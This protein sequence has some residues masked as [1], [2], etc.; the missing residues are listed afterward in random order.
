MRGLWLAAALGAAV[1]GVGGEARAFCV[2]RGCSESRQDCEYDARGCLLSGPVLHWASSCVSFGVQKDGSPRRGIS[3]DT[4]HAAIV[5]GFSQWMNARCG[6]GR[7]PSIRLSDS[8][9]IECRTPEYNED[10]P[11]ANVLMF[12]DDDWPYDNSVD[13]LALTTL[14][15]DAKSGEIY[16]ADVEVNT[17]QSGMVTGEVGPLDVDFDSVIT[18]ELGHF[19]GLSHSSAEGST[20][21]RSY[22][23]GQTAMASIEYDDEQGIC[24]ALPPDRPVSDTSCEPRHGFSEL[25]GL[26][27]S[28]AFAPA[29]SSSGWPSALLVTLG[30][31]WLARRK[32]PHPS[33]RRP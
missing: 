31:S 14:I 12:R 2:T 18:H 29:R 27:E 11:N 10:G 6:E 13:T 9:P 3:Y 15:Y 22:A 28:C 19:L 20:M 25:C 26:P 33:S 8:G 17:F 16:D 21:S 23:P 7:T 4:A 5:A 30:L 32:R 24:A 1:L